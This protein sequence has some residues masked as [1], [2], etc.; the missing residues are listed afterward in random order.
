LQEGVHWIVL[1]AVRN[2]A[3]FL[4]ARY[5]TVE[6]SAYSWA[7]LKV[8][9]FDNSLGFGM[10]VFQVA[11]DGAEDTINVSENILFDADAD[12]WPSNFVAAERTVG[13]FLAD[14]TPQ[15]WVN[16]PIASDGDPNGAD[17]L[18]VIE[19]YV[20]GNHSMILF[21]RSAVEAQLRDQLELD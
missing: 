10:P 20:E 19:D 4:R 13:T 14:G 15:A 5:G 16:Y 1:D 11:T 6:P 7:D 12:L 21:E 17:G 3:E 9:S 18:Q 2:T 8:T